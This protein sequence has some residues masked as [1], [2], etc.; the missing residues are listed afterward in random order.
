MDAGVG[1]E[2]RIEKDMGHFMGAL[3]AAC[4]SRFTTMTRRAICLCAIPVIILTV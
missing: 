2:Q 3:L 1:L 4:R